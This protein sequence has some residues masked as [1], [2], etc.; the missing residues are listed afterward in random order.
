LT[1]IDD[2][3]LQ[4]ELR[5]ILDIQPAEPIPQKGRRAGQGAIELKQIDDLDTLR[6][7]AEENRVRRAQAALEAELLVEE[8]LAALQR[9][10]A[11]SAVSGTYSS[12]LHETRAAFELE[13]TRLSSGRL[14]HLDAR[15]REAVQRWARL[16]FGR[17][18][19]VPLSALKRLARAD[20]RPTHEWEGLE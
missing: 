7:Q 3:R 2:P 12:V 15:D 8:Q 9:E 13:L 10:H 19:H 16:T 20:T 4:A 14:A 11:A 5:T 6:A 18:A 1:P 17:L